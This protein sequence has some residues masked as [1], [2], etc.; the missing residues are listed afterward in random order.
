LLLGYETCTATLKD[1]EGMREFENEEIVRVIIW[2]H[3]MGSITT[4]K[5]SLYRF[6]QF[7]LFIK[8]YKRRIKWMGHLVCMENMY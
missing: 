1:E 8:R 5:I 6:S 4:E 7:V 2:T 3:K